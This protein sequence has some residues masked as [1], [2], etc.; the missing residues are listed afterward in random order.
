M[1]TVCK[2]VTRLS[3]S[4]NASESGLTAG[5]GTTA[6]LFESEGGGGTGPGRE[7]G[8]SFCG[9]ECVRDG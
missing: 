6:Q 9:S 7:G 5:G 2:L 4:L 3:A 1:I 8:F